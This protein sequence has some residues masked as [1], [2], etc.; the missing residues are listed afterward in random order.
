MHG[1]VICWPDIAVPYRYV[2]LLLHTRRPIFTCLG[3]L[4]LPPPC[5]QA[6]L[7]CPWSRPVLAYHC[8]AVLVQVRLQKKRKGLVRLDT[9]IFWPPSPGS[10]TPYQ[11]R[12]RGFLVRQ[13]K[14]HHKRKSSSSSSSQP[15]KGRRKR[16]AASR[17]LRRYTS[18]INPEGYGYT[19]FCATRLAVSH[20][21]YNCSFMA[22]DFISL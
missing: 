18:S 22:L 2:L 21:N 10:H 15:S 5:K 6:L 11:K 19:D 20:V 13:K 4:N 17:Q 1:G 7:S 9:Y 12:V 3:E 14:C 16:S 8:A